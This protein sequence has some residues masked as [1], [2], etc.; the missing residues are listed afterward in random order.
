VQPGGVD[1]TTEVTDVTPI[2]VAKLTAVDWGEAVA[3][4]TNVSRASKVTQQTAVP[5]LTG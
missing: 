2:E 5:S 4:P 1:H 3:L